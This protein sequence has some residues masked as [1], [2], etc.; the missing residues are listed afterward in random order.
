MYVLN[1]FTVYFHNI[2]SIT[3]EPSLQSFNIYNN[4]AST[5][6]F[7]MVVCAFSLATSYLSFR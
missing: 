7:I 2:V 6:I 4:S 3:I 1:K 5:K